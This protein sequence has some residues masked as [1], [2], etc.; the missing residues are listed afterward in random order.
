M[1]TIDHTKRRTYEFRYAPKMN[2]R[3]QERNSAQVH[4]TPQQL[5]YMPANQDQN[6][7]HSRYTQ[8]LRTN[9]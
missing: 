6:N 8:K 1:G 2:Y 4:S 7:D 3:S 9:L 5:Q